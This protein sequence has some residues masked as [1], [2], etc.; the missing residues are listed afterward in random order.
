LSAHARELF[1]AIANGGLVRRLWILSWF[2]WKIWTE[3]LFDLSEFV[4]ILRR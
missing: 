4:L 3:F 1:H 2:L